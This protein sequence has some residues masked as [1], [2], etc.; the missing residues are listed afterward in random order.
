MPLVFYRL[1]LGFVLGGRFLLLRHVGRKSGL[2][3]ETVLEVVHFDESSGTYTIASGF[4]PR[5]DWY[6]NLLRH[7]QASI[8]VRNRDM[9][10]IA[11]PLSPEASGETMVRY[12]KQYP[13][14][15]KALPGLLGFRVDGGEEDYRTL[16]REHIPF[17]DL[18]P[19]PPGM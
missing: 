12:L 10:V 13:Q 17:V 2:Q 18:E 3:R 16:G 14:A 9:D 1:R 4:G 15:A 5:S 7:P 6:Q 11:K 19:A 8:R